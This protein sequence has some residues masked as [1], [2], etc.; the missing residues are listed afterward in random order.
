MYGQ[1][2][3]MSLVIKPSGGSLAQGGCIR[4]TTKDNKNMILQLYRGNQQ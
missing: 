1:Y 2:N 3:A 4:L